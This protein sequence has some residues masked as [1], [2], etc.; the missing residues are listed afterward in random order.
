MRA[1]IE[2][3]PRLSAKKNGAA[4]LLSDRSVQNILHHDT[5]LHLYNIITKQDLNANNFKIL[6][7]LFENILRNVTLKLLSSA[8]TGQSST[9]QAQLSIKI[10]G[11][12][13]K[14]TLE[15]FIK[16]QHTA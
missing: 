4:L 13:L 15:N 10:A 16:Q 2:Q 3:S 5:E 14:K 9:F 7:M 11:T 6:Q 12:G 1:S 8:R